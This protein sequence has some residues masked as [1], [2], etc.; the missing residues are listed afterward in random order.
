MLFVVTDTGWSTILRLQNM[1]V[2]GRVDFSVSGLWHFEFKCIFS[3]L[4]TVHEGW[5]EMY[6]AFSL[7]FH[8][9]S[10]YSSVYFDFL[11][12]INFLH[13]TFSQYTYF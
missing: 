13:A 5:K 10:L 6:I 3:R 7:V 11:I 4:T 12:F 1:T 2:D 9:I 8:L